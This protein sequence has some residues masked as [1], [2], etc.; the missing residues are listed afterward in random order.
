MTTTDTFTHAGCS[1][2]IWRDDWRQESL[3]AAL[4]D[5]IAP[6]TV[7]S[8]G[9]SGWYEVHDG[10]NINAFADECAPALMTNWHGIAD[11][12]DMPHANFR[13]ALQDHWDN[14]TQAA[15]YA[16]PFTWRDLIHDMWSQDTRDL[17]AM[18]GLLNIIG[19]P[20]RVF[21]RNGYSQGDSIRVLLAH[22]PEWRKA[23]GIQDARSD[24]EIKAD[25]EADADSIAAWAF[26]DCYGFTVIDD[27]P[28]ATSDDVTVGGFW[29][30]YGSPNYDYM[31]E[32]AKREAEAMA[33][34]RD[35]ML[36]A[37]LENDRPDLYQNVA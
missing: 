4:G 6:C 30:A 31:I 33:A 37:D 5:G 27:H 28:E 23:M 26:G 18:A 34:E 25:M 21:E 11:L 17:R 19:V 10:C 7:E 1:I 13:E 20:A 32:E 35:A 36:A 15:P 16:D 24:D 8:W 9:R 2:E 12:M 22:T 3:T 14:C 29:G